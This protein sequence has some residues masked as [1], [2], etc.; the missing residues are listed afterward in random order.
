MTRRVYFS[1]HYANDARRV[2]Q[3]R[4]MGAFEDDKPV[5]P[6]AW[7]EIKRK[8]DGAVEKWIDE[9][10]SQCSCVAVLIGSETASRKWVKYEIEHAWRSNKGLLG[11]Y[12]HNIKDPI[13]GICSKGENPFTKVRVDYMNL[14]NIIHCHNP[15]SYDAYRDIRMNLD[16]WVEDAIKIRNLYL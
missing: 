1:F 13:S 14:S 9:K 5:S 16:K 4:N 7:E 2:Q 6:S 11:I 8:G 12:I 15:D 3:I 10:M